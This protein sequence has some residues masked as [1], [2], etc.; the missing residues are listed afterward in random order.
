M[1]EISKVDVTGLKE[2]AR[3]SVIVR[4]L[5]MNAFA[6]RLPQ[7]AFRLHRSPHLAPPDK[8][9]VPRVEYF[10]CPPY[11]TLCSTLLLRPPYAVPFSVDRSVISLSADSSEIGCG[12]VVSFG[13]QD[14]L[15][16]RLRS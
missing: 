10:R 7:N 3:C 14:S 4:R 11:L 13:E 5:C 12:G 9:A 1:L 15:W 16:I 8:V 2:R 6:S